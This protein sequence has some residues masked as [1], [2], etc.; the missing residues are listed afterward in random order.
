MR[1][2]FIEWIE[3]ELKKEP[4]SGQQSFQ[5]LAKRLLVG[6][7]AFMLL[8]TVISRAADSITVAKVSTE[9]GKSGVLSFEMSGDGTVEADQ[10]EYLDVLEGVRIR[11]IAAREGQPVEKGEILFTYDRKDLQKQYDSL[12]ND[13]T[14][15]ALTL[16]KSQLQTEADTVA[17]ETQLAEVT[18]KRAQLDLQL[19]KEE[20]Q[21][22]KRKLG[23]DK[24]TQ[25]ETAEDAVTEAAEARSEVEEN[26]N[27][28][29]LAAKDE[30]DAAREAW[31][32]L[33]K[34]QQKLEAAVEKYKAAALSSKLALSELKPV[35]T[36]SSSSS[37]GKNNSS[38]SYINEMIQ[39]GESYTWMLERAFSQIEQST[40][41]DGIAPIAQAEAE[42]FRQY[43]G[44][45]EYE[46]HAEEVRQ[47]QKTLARA[48]EDY[49]LVF[50]DATENGSLLTTSRKASCI[51]AYEDACS[52]LEDLTKKDSSIS[53]AILAYGTAVQ[54]KEDALANKAYGDL[55]LLLL[56][57]DEV[58]Q[59]EIAAAQKRIT[60]ACDAL[61]RV[62][63]DGKRKLQKADREESK[64]KKQLDKLQTSEYQE[65]TEALKK[66]VVT[67]QRAVEDAKAA[68]VRAKETDTRTLASNLSKDKLRRIDQETAQLELQ[69][70]QE[71]VD[72]IQSIIE[73][74][75]KVS[76]PVSG[77]VLHCEL[78]VGSKTTGAERVSVSA[79]EYSFSAM[80]PKEDAKHLTTGDE[81]K[82]QFENNQS[83]ITSVIESLAPADSQG[84]VRVTALLPKGE[85]GVGAAATFKVQKRSKKY[86]QTVPLQAVRMDGN[87]TNY[88]LIL[89]ESNTSLGK[90]FI[91]ARRNIKVLEKDAQTAAIEGTLGPEDEIIVSSS[92]SIE[93]GDRV[94]S[95]EEKQ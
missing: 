40:P 21:A 83:E 48:K 89:Q 73:R 16:E 9:Q 41:M 57:D 39:I 47:A 31:D 15:A 92:K 28:S 91:A 19:A 66:Q 55:F 2:K 34:K 60:T 26:N 80:L 43:Y 4:K 1:N 42:I 84:L 52:A 18:L 65:E 56:P 45:E 81:I 49:L 54:K 79:D 95:Y 14:V 10:E 61:T 67:A 86:D 59:K 13:L 50:I 93:E 32:D 74:K 37:I 51:R 8:F 29:I 46:K 85:Y 58:R 33:L 68:L 12:Q 53:N 7:F 76:A 44:E 87:Q 22:A 69:E 88:V 70:K 23:D 35:S 77:V 24:V 30:I 94:R 3:K 90:E 71:A 27:R 62:Q 75:G 11:E 6:F 72:Q 63:A 78:K 17:G 38:V 20:L 64:A 36:D 82:I 5:E 25:L